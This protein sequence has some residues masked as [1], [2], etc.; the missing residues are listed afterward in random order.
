ME[1]VDE[2][3]VTHPQQLIIDHGGAILFA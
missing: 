2:E 1:S 3:V